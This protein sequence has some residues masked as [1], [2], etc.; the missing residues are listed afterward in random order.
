M[1]KVGILG[2]GGISG[3]HING[4]LNIPEAKITALCDI[5]PRRKNKS[6]LLYQF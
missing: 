1:L 6:S 3:A 2:V 4:W 5:R